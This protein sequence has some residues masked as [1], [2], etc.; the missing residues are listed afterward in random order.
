M[1]E[2]SVEGMDVVVA[3]RMYI[4][5]MLNDCGEG[6]KAF[7]LDKVTLAIVTQAYTQSEL[8]QKG[9]Y[10]FELLDV[11]RGGDP[12]KHVNAIVFVQP[13]IVNIEAL[14][15]ELGSPYYNSYFLYF[16]HFLEGEGLENALSLL[17]KSDEQEV[18]KE[19]KE[20]YY[21]YLPVTS[22]LF[23]L[24]LPPPI[25]YVGRWDPNLLARTCRSL[26]TVLLSLRCKPVIRY[27]NG[28]M[29]EELARAVLAAYQ[30]HPRQFSTTRKSNAPPPPLLLIMDR[31]SDPVTP[32]LSPWTYH[33]QVHEL[34]TI[35]RN[36]LDSSEMGGLNAETNE[37]VFSSTVDDFLKENMY[38]NFGEIGD[39]VQ[40]VVME[41]QG[42]VKDS[43]KLDTIQEMK[44]FVEN[45][46]QFR[47]LA[48][49]TFKHLGVTSDMSKIVHEHSLLK[50]SEVEQ[51]IVE[52]ESRSGA[53]EAVLGLLGDKSIQPYEC[54]RLCMLFQLRY[55]RGK[56]VDEIRQ[57]L[58]SILSEGPDLVDAVLRYDTKRT[59][60][61]FARHNITSKMKKAIRTVLKGKVE[62]TENIYVRH[63][64][65]L[66]EVLTTLLEGKLPQDKYPLL[67]PREVEISPEYKPQRVIV[68]FV[69]GATYSEAKVVAD[70]SA[71]NK[72]C[73]IILGGTYIHNSRSFLQ[74]VVMHD[75]PKLSPQFPY[76]LWG[77]SRGAKSGAKKKLEGMNYLF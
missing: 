16:S 29:T 51:E 70:M 5:Q 48:A 53:K 11:V 68:F 18:L 72:P 40:E 64:P 21:E 24:S 26:T 71:A 77:I 6:M 22:N 32:L 44:E 75:A 4:D 54:V 13:T 36:K 55:E 49:T 47:K 66:K 9:V 67:H 45:Y 2:R 7:L 27:V 61:L 23:T 15:K 10:L 63:K 30:S 62:G 69:G 74:E 37:L 65:S 33:A 19:V 58:K 50:V 8:G 34:Y 38:L 73:R 59:T 35:F 57:K 12:M 14:C 17:A 41:Y 60:E 28:N 31:H 46:P 20:M 76:A 25:P 56:D 42:K 1:A 39:K 52:G 3:I 43:R